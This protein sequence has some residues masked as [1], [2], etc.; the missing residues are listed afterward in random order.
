MSFN[1][2]L[3]LSMTGFGILKNLSYA[4]G[5]HKNSKVVLLAEIV[6]KGLNR[7]PAPRRSRG[8]IFLRF[9]PTFTKSH[10]FSDFIL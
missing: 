4:Y 2:G 3:L 9:P 8:F 1:Y 7:L 6:E 5:I 10:L